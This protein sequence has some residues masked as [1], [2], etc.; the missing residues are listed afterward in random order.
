MEQ[1]NN[2]LGNYVSKFM[3]S[4]ENMSYLKRIIVMTS[5]SLVFF[6]SSILIRWYDK[7]YGPFSWLFVLIALLT[8]PFFC[9]ELEGTIFGALGGIT[10]IIRIFILHE[11]IL[12]YFFKPETVNFWLYVMTIL[13]V[14]LITS[15]IGYFLGKVRLTIMKEL[16]GRNAIAKIALEKFSTLSEQTI[17]GIMSIKEGKILDV[18]EGASAILGYEIEEIENWTIQKLSEIIHE[19]DRKIFLDFVEKE[20]QKIVDI[21]DNQIIKIIS[22]IDE[23]KWVDLSIKETQMDNSRVLIL[24]IFDITEIKIA[25]DQ[26]KHIVD[27]I[28]FLIDRIRNHLLVIIGIIEMR[29]TTIADEV[30]EQIDNIVESMNQV[31]EDIFETL[32]LK[33]ELEKYLGK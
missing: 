7:L 22:E 11:E 4:I 13:L 3:N 9:N 32:G 26:L 21:G 8:I 30:K 29:E 15:S 24:R 5:I 28:Y 23:N 6:S 33:E 10:I 27:Q 14:F 16:K 31:E 18:N 17:F 12:E 1:K 19:D 25:Y 20:N 2:S